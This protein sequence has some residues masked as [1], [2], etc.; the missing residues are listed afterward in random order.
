MQLKQLTLAV[1][2]ATSLLV[3]CSDEPKKSDKGTKTEQTALK[4]AD[5]PQKAEDQY[6]ANLA[7]AAKT[8]ENLYAQNPMRGLTKYQITV[9]DYQRDPRI[10]PAP[11]WR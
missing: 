4:A 3:A 2:T 5:L 10:L 8:Y 7:L 1:L 11:L 6:K 9:N